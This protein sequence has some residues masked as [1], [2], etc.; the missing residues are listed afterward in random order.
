MCIRATFHNT[1]NEMSHRKTI[2]QRND[3]ASP[4]HKTLVKQ[5]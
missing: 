5:K 3:Q 4:R 1:L 2:F